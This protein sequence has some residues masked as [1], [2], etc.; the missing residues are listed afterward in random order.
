MVVNLIS[1]R[2]G[3]VRENNSVRLLQT[4][5]SF[6]MISRTPAVGTYIER[7]VDLL[8]KCGHI[9]LLHEDVDQLQRDYLQIREWENSDVLIVLE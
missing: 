4:L 7:T 3:V 2:T 1:K 8:T 5:P 6:H 9:Y